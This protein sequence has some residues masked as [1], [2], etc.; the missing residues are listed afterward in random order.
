M[1]EQN[2][3]QHIAV[4]MDGNRRWA[5]ERGLP[6]LEGHRKVADE[7]LEPLIEH[8]AKRGVK[9]MTFWAFSTE[10]WNRSEKE[11]QGIM[12]IFRHVIQK[13]WQILHEKGVKIRVIGDMMRF[14]QDIKDALTKVIEQTKDNTKITI[15]FALNY[16]GR[17]EM[18]R[19]MNKSRGEEDTSK[20]TFEQHLDTAGIPDPELI[21]RT[22]GEQRL[23]GFLLW[24]SEYSELLFPSWYM[25][26]F[27]PE[28][29]DELIEEY[30]TRQRR[31][32]K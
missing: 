19:A 29:L 28:R 30:S 13:R 31:F 10:N 32:G 2:I 9:Y 17:D 5:K 15:V 4:I 8:A 26:E 11:V 14:S 23:S 21:I 18:I 3:P 27:T 12:S 24:Q 22:G 16:G 1:E 20:K 7:I 25:P 6:I